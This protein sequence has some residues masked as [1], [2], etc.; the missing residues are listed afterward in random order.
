METPKVKLIGG[1]AHGQIIDPPN[2]SGEIWIPYIEGNRSMVDV[3]DASATTYIKQAIYK[4]VTKEFYMEES[5]IKKNIDQM[6]TL[7]QILFDLIIPI[8]Q[9]NECATK[10]RNYRI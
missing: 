2:R 4:K 7:E 1:P 3:F 8:N 5:L 9:L 6:K 10:G